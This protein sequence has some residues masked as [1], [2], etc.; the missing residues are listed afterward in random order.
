M[1]DKNFD[2]NVRRIQ[3]IQKKGVQRPP[4]RTPKIMINRGVTMYHPSRSVIPPVEGFYDVDIHVSLP[5]GSEKTFTI[6]GGATI[7]QLFHE[8]HKFTK[9]QKK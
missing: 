6:T 4:T 2:E 3:E 8:V 9:K 7:T 1:S 5:D